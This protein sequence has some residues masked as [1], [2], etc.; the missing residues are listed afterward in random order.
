MI[1]EMIENVRMKPFAKRIVRQLEVVIEKA[2][3]ALIHKV[4]LKLDNKDLWPLIQYL[5]DLEVEFEGQRYLSFQLEDFAEEALK[6][7]HTDIENGNLDDAKD[8]FHEGLQ[9]VLDQGLLLFYKEPM[10]ILKL[11]FVMRKVVDIGY[12][13][14]HKA[15]KPAINKIVHGMDIEELESLKTYID[16]LTAEIED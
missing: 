11:S 12:A 15:V 6:Q 3:N 7:A 5:R 10:S 14:I 8:N 4:I 2:A 1:L 13:A 9:N 16:S